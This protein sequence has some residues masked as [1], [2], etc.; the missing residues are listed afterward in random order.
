[1][2]RTN[3]RYG[4]RLNKT[5]RKRA[6]V[7]GKSL[8]Y[9]Q[10]IELVK[11]YSENNDVVQTAK[12]MGVVYNTA[13]RIL[14]RYEAFG[15][16]PSGLQRGR[17]ADSGRYMNE[18]LYSLVALIFEVLP[19]AF[20]AEVAAII[21]EM[22]D[23]SEYED[24]F[25]HGN[26][27]EKPFK[28]Q[29]RYVCTIR[30]KKIDY[31]C[32]RVAKIALNRL[33]P[34]VQAKRKTFSDKIIEAIGSHEFLISQFLCCDEQ[35]YDRNETHRAVGKSKRGERILSAEQ[36]FDCQS[37]SLVC[38]ITYYGVLKW[39]LYPSSGT[40][41]NQKTFTD[42]LRLLYPVFPEYG[43]LLLDGAKIHWTTIVSNVLGYR[44]NLKLPP[45][46]PDFMAIELFFGYLKMEVKRRCYLKK[47]RNLRALINEIITEANQTPEL[48]K[49]FYRKAFSNILNRI[50][51]IN[52]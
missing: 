40:A 33:T 1:M 16:V 27:Y 4:Y 46:S 47:Y 17:R 45:F 8:S 18:K 38:T 21:N 30:N 13:K 25:N 50:D 14:Q 39:E 23:V 15:V 43:I 31:T 24:F 44:P 41:C 20:D 48:F 22:E 12:H 26:T 34:R 42:Y 37:W 10:R 6:Y 49:G 36:S 9:E 32:K 51:E 7:K 35:H 29:G 2:I 19:K 28:M 11:T 5:K 52:N 3:A